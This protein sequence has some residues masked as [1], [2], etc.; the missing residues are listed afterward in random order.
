MKEAILYLLKLNGITQKDLADVLGITY[1]TL[2][3]KINGHKDFTQ[4]EIMII[5]QFFRLSPE[6]LCY[7]F[8]TYDEDREE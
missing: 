4:S 8:F 7:I 6:Q 1:Q 2:N 5:K 3:I